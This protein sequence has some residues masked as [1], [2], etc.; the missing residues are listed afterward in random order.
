M[1]TTLDIDD[2]V[3]AAAKEVAVTEAS[4]AGAI[5]S[6]WARKGLT[7]SSKQS[8]RSSTGFPVFSV[9]GDAA[10]LTSASVNALIDDERLPA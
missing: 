4:T 7:Q 3:L 8:R 9:P 1:R 10:P 2:A 6:K 5:I